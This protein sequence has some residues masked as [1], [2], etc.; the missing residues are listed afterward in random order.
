LPLGRS[1]NIQ[2]LINKP[3][4]LTEITAEECVQEV[5]WNV[6]VLRVEN[7]FVT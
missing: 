6:N 1:A 3:L 4:I 2:G 7:V 5:Y